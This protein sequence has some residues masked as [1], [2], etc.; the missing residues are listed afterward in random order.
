MLHRLRSDAR[1]IIGDNEPYRVS[2]LT[3]YGVI[4]HA[5]RRRIPYV[6]L[7]IRQDLI[8]DEAGQLLWADLLANVLV[9]AARS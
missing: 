2:E 6:E 7:E 3:D 4:Q 1:W 5:E 8:A 9:D